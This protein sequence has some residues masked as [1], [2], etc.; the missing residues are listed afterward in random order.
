MAGKECH[1]H[2]LRNNLPSQAGDI[3]MYV[4]INYLGIFV[5]LL[6]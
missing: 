5:H 2:D 1:L 3:Y 6:G 4:M